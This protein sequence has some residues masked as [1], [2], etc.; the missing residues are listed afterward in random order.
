MVIVADTFYPGWRA[1]IDGKPAE[2]REVYGALRG[3][4]VDGGAHEIEMRFQ[5]ISVYGGAGLT[6]FGTM[7]AVVAWRRRK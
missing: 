2:I 1:T 4:V 5:P 7:M 3:V 6:M